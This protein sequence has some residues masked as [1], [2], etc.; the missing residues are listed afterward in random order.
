MAALVLSSAE[1]SALHQHYKS[2]VRQLLRLPITTRESFVMF[3]AG[4]LPATAIVHLRT[5]TLLG[6]IG[7]VGPEVILNKI[8]RYSLL[9]ATN[10]GPGSLL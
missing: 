10:K 2:S 8:G 1:I 5:L 9:S 6:M 4:S 7:R 3:L